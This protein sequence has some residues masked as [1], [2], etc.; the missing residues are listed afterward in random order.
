MPSSVTG[1]GT[2]QRA[3]IA[4]AL[5]DQQR[6]QLSQQLM[7]NLPRESTARAF[8]DANL[9]FNAVWSINTHTSSGFVYFPTTIL[10]SIRFSLHLFLLKS[11]LKLI[12]FKFSHGTQR[13]QAD[14]GRQKS[15]PGLLKTPKT[16]VL[17]TRW[18][19]ETSAT[20]WRVRAVM[21][22]VHL[23]GC[24]M[25]NRQDLVQAVLVDE[26]DEIFN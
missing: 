12:P 8:K 7:L 24:K 16:S 3:V 19:T 26:G 18:M 5:S 9:G 4:A 15:G 1:S 17:R 11:W 20:M 22:T 14:S 21:Y 10:Q 6:L 23:S 2:G 25:S 13:C